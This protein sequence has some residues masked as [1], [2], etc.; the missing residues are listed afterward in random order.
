MLGYDGK[1]KPVRHRESLL[2]MAV[3]VL[4][5]VLLTWCT[6][7]AVRDNQTVSNAKIEAA[8]QSVQQ[9]FS[10]L[11]QEV[12][13]LRDDTTKDKSSSATLF[14][15]ETK[16]IASMVEALKG[17]IPSTSAIAAAA[18]ASASSAISA[19]MSPLL[20]QRPARQATSG[21]GAKPAPARFAVMGMAKNLDIEPAHTFVRSL[22]RHM[23]AGEVDVFIF[24]D[25][26]SL[27]AQI[28]ALYESHGVTVIVFDPAK[29]FPS[30][31]GYHPSSYRWMLIRDHL[32]QL[33]T[34]AGYKKGNDNG[35]PPPYDQVFFVDVRDTA[36][37]GSPFVRNGI[38]RKSGLTVFL[39]QKV[40][41]ISE[42]GW[43]SKWVKDCFG[44]AGVNLV[45]QSY[46]SC[47][48][49]TMGAWDDAVAYASLIGTYVQAHSSC[50]GNGIDQGL[51]N[52]FLYSGDLAKE[53]SAITIVNNEDGFVGTVQS[54]PVVMQDE[55]GNVLNAK[56][57]PF[58][59][60]HQYDRVE[61]LTTQ[62]QQQYPIFPGGRTINR[63]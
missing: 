50:E 15:D 56:N 11:S 55:F 35:T 22:R 46:I 4:I 7:T 25:E 47:S 28:R 41:R 8:V 2:R 5:A 14:R 12:A 31:A 38:D 61:A 29:D 60:V 52:Y 17:E 19:A 18:G 63:G 54:M 20:Q 51:H 21:D 42:C 44:D 27:T 40:R 30:Q 13:A 10:R 48:G 24:A 37:Q 59:A 39:E 16:R 6:I 45:G 43:N 26:P 36:W 33:E 9:Q 32:K 23:P 1:D 57:E 62:Y 53:V 58:A 3:P 34:K 49:T